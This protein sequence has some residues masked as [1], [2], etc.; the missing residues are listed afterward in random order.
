MAPEEGRGGHRPGRPLRLEE[1]LW[2]WARI[3]FGKLWTDMAVQSDKQ[4][5]MALF[6][7]YEL[8]LLQPFRER[9]WLQAGGGTF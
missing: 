1:E 9:R 5:W 3:F 4:E 6:G 7:S 2:W 8:W